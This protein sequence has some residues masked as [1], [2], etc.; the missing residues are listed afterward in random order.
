M[1]YLVTGGTGFIG[2]YVVRD[3]LEAGKKVICLQRSGVT[4]L[5]REL[6][7]EESTAKVKIVQADVSDLSQ[8]WEAIRENQVELI[9]HLSYVLPPLS[10]REPPNALRVNCLGLNN[11]LEAVRHF[12]L[13][14]LV[15]TSSSRAL[16]CLAD[17][18][19]EPV[20]GD[21]AVY[22][23]DDFYGAT[24]VLGE[25]MLKHYFYKFRTDAIAIR[26]A[27]TF[28]VGKTTGTGATLAQFLRNAALNIPATIGGASKVSVYQYVEDTADLIVKACETPTPNSRIFC[29]GEELTTRQ[30]VEIICRVNPQARI[31]VDERTDTGMVS[32]TASSSHIKDSARPTVGLGWQ[33]KYT[34]EEGIRKMFNYF[35]QRE[36][37]SAL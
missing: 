36:G 2:S 8:V 32:I 34:V 25:V 3:L 1:A 6:V 24:K 21:D 33:P 9:I 19:S 29:P 22:M 4:P 14:R 18:W 26:T 10:E 37:M 27:R 13:R 28:G 17:F 5:F 23:P 11:M 30:L 15:W 31:S 12:G 7:G 35:R 16:G 20:G